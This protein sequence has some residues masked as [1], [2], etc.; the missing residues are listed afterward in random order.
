MTSSKI[1]VP[2]TG[3][4]AEGSCSAPAQRMQP[5]RE[6]TVAVSALAYRLVSPD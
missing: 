5:G 6:Q 1:L 3:R 4:R 2:M